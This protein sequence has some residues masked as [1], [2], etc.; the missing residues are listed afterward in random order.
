[1]NLW[2]LGCSS[3]PSRPL[4]AGQALSE[5]ELPAG[6]LLVQPPCVEIEQVMMGVTVAHLT[7]AARGLPLAKV[8]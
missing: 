8:V 1:M 7:P 3:A 5:G 2:E 6:L 4:V